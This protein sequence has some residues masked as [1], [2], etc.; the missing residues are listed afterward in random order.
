M[1]GAEAEQAH[2]G[3]GDLRALEAAQDE[4]QAES[5]MNM[6]IGLFSQIDG[7]N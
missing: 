4:R 1:Q 5:P 7:P 6:K 3:A 2:G